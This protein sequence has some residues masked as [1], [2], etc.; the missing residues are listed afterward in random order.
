ME[1]LLALESA[2]RILATIWQYCKKKMKERTVSFIVYII[3]SKP[4]SLRN[5]L[6]P[7]QVRQCS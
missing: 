7:Q 1:Q 6:P 4:H 5:N 3:Q 2:E